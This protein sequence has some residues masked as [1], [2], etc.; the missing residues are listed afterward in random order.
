MDRIPDNV[1]IVYKPFPVGGVHG[2]IARFPD[3]EIYIVINSNEDEEQQKRSL[4]HELDHY[5]Q[6]DLLSSDVDVDFAE[7]AAHCMHG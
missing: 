2:L 3:G 6:G 7:M 4:E 1:K 5:L